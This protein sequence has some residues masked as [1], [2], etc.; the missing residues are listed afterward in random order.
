MHIGFPDQLLAALHLRRWTVLPW[1][2]G[3]CGHWVAEGCNTDR[4]CS[5]QSSSLAGSHTAHLVT[6]A[7]G[8]SCNIELNRRQPS[9]LGMQRSDASSGSLQL[10][11]EHA[12]IVAHTNAAEP[13]AV[14]V[15]GVAAA[16][17]LRC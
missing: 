4:R 9:R 12:K 1:T 10:S 7:L 2:V 17:H 8:L 3:S 16:G 13:V 11:A 15:C 14:L 5:L 6:V